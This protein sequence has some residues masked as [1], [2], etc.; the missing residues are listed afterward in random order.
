MASRYF[1]PLVLTAATILSGCVT[2]GERT[3]QTSIDHSFI[4]SGFR[5]T[6]GGTVYIFVAARENQGKVEV[7][8]ARM[9]TRSPAATL[10]FDDKVL[11]AASV[12]VDGGRVLTGLD[13][14]N[15]LSETNDVLGKPA[16]CVRTGK[17]WK[18][19]Y[20]GARVEVEIPRQ[21]FVD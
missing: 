2:S 13:F 21:R 17:S 18:P 16:T 5:W 19:E 6:V 15:V 9:A 4:T 10:W 11:A 8:A 12:R 20:N 14:A 7:C 1:T 3:G